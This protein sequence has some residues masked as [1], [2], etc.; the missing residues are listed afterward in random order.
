MAEYGYVAA[1]V[2]AQE[3]K[4]AY[5]SDPADTGYDVVLLMGQ[6]NMQGADGVIS[7]LV[8]V[9]SPRIWTY[10]STGTN[11]NKVIQAS[12]PLGHLNASTS[13]VGPGMS[14]AHWYAGIIPGNR[15]V[16]LVP[17]A[18]SGSGF[19]NTSGTSKWDPFPAFPNTGDNLYNRTIA[20]ATAA[21]AAAGANSRIVAALWAQGEADINVA[22]TTYRTYLESLIDGLR[23]RLS[24]PNL[25]FVIGSMVPEYAGGGTLDLVHQGTPTRKPYTSYVAGP[26]G[27]LL[28][29]G[30]GVHYNAAGAREQG[31]RLVVGL[32]AAKANSAPSGAVA[33]N[34]PALPGTVTTVTGLSSVTDDFTTLSAGYA[35]QNGTF[36]VSAGRLQVPTVAAYPVLRGPVYGSLV[37]SSVSIELISMP[38]TGQSS[39]TYGGF[40]VTKNAAN[41]NDY[42]GFAFSG[43]TSAQPKDVYVTPEFKI[44]N[45][46]QV[47]TTGANGYT[48]S[49]ADRFYRIR[50]A[51]GTI[52]WETSPNGT[53]WTSRASAANTGLDLSNVTPFW[54]GGHW[55][56]ADADGVA[57]FDNLNLFT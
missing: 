17:C 50:E 57:V 52:Y 29:D 27:Y 23:S 4:A 19:L 2:Q 26:T 18:S 25:P 32:V 12:D 6:S 15:R 42:V 33:A 44:G 47:V 34:P 3:L 53:T 1:L 56:A 49:T 54:Q 37:G 13:G 41:Q 38:Q 40:G 21:L 16:L 48:A 36:T 8:D 11:A 20:Q 5:G 22:S 7:P 51:G 31:R 24:L 28:S 55:N 43:A 14:F 45:A 35:A 10:P 39:S 30:L 9:T 46:G